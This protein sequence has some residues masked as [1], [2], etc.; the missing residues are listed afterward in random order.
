MRSV[1]ILYGV[2]AMKTTQTL[3]ILSFESNNWNPFLFPSSPAKN[4]IIFKIQNMCK[5]DQQPLMVLIKKNRKGGSFGQP[6]IRAKRGAGPLRLRRE[7]RAL[8]RSEMGWVESSNKSQ[9]K[10]ST[11]GEDTKSPPFTVPIRSWC[12]FQASEAVLTAIWNPR[13]SIR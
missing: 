9:R 6:R 8:K 13:C 11:S 12:R 4:N 10:L 2:I 5:P 1:L 7:K 3:I